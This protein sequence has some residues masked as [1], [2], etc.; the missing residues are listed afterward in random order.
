M[1]SLPLVAECISERKD[2]QVS[3]VRFANMLTGTLF[4]LDYHGALSNSR[5]FRW[6]NYHV[7]ALVSELYVI[8]IIESSQPHH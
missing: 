2:K 1:Q 3:M 5:S 8:H 7:Q 6:I 4:G